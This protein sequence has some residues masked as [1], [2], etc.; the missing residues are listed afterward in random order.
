MPDYRSMTTISGEKLDV[1]VEM[2]ELLRNVFVGKPIPDGLYGVDRDT[3]LVKVMISPTKS[4]NMKLGRLLRKTGFSEADCRD[5]SAQLRA[6]ILIRNGLELKFTSSGEEAYEVYEDGPRSCMKGS[7]SVVAYNSDNVAI[8]YV[9]EDGRVIARAAVCTCPDL[10]LR[11]SAIY[12]NDKV[13]KEMLED[14]GYEDGD[15]EGCTLDKVYCED[16][17]LILMPYL[18]CGTGATEYGD[19]FILDG[20]PVYTQ[21]EGGTIGIV[22]SMCRVGTNEEFIRRVECSDEDMCESC[23]NEYIIFID[24]EAYFTDSPDIIVLENG[25]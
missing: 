2:P 21:N 12:G 1:M 15:L 8:A 3:G 23:F 13:L 4:E 14:A 20:G 18:D 9:E 17:G 25:D 6:N 16:S 11:Y 5:I 19:H 10:G 24:G 22:C 7:R